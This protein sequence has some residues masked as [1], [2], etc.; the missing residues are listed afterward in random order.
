MSSIG[1]S[2]KKSCFTTRHFKF[3]IFLF[4]CRDGKSFTEGNKFFSTLLALNASRVSLFIYLFTFILLW[5]TWRAALGKRNILVMQFVSNNWVAIWV[6][7][8][9]KPTLRLITKYNILQHIRTEK[10]RNFI[11]ALALKALPQFHLHWNSMK[12]MIK[13]VSYVVEI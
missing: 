4:P 10:P 8:L 2:Y 6:P 5:Q 9:T 13:S 11:I 7:G 1:K 12:M 3:F